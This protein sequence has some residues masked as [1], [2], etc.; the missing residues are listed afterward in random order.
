VNRSVT[1]DDNNVGLACPSLQK[2]SEEDARDE[3]P[4]RDEG[5][6]KLSMNPSKKAVESVSP[7]GM[8]T[9]QSCI[10]STSKQMTAKMGAIK[11]RVYWRHTE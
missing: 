5:I 2:S 10:G 4:Q 6:S 3:R 11:G 1:G 7:G 8:G 9:T